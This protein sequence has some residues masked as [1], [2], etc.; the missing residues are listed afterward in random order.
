MVVRQTVFIIRST[1][2]P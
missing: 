1:V 2:N